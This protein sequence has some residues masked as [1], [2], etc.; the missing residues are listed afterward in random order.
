MVKKLKSAPVPTAEEDKAALEE[1]RINKL[2]ND[3]LTAK[4]KTEQKAKL[5]KKTSN[6]KAKKEEAKVKLLKKKL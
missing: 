2:I 6:K 5:E 3:I 1:E 4:K